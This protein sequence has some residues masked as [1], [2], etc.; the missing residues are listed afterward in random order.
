MNIPIVSRWRQRRAEKAFAE[1]IAELGGEIN[2]GEL[3]VAGLLTPKRLRSS[4]VIGKFPLPFRSLSGVT[5]ELHKGVVL[6]TLAAQPFEHERLNLPFY[7]FHFENPFVTVGTVES[8][9]LSRE[10]LRRISS[11]GHVSLLFKKGKPVVFLSGLQKVTAYRWRNKHWL[12]ALRKVDVFAGEGDRHLLHF[13]LAEKIAK[14]MQK[15]GIRTELH[16]P[17]PE[18]LCDAGK[19]EVN[20]RIRRPFKELEKH[21][22]RDSLKIAGK[23]MNTINLSR[24]KK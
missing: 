16:V 12:D 18:H 17:A 3:G 21:F 10:Q 20:K 6:C 5:A 9:A 4:Y 22:E 24:P 8:A 14:A 15:K 13:T 2:A 23:E 7:S 1:A 11:F 19:E